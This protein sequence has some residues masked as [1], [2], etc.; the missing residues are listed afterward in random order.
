M[1]QIKSENIK[2]Y[3][4][5]SDL[6]SMSENLIKDFERFNAKK[7]KKSNLDFRETEWEYSIQ[8]GGIL[9][10]LFDS[11]FDHLDK[12][13]RNIVGDWKSENKASYNPNWAKGKTFENVCR[14]WIDN[15]DWTLKSN[16]TTKSHAIG[17]KTIAE[18]I[19]RIKT[20]HNNV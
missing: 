15:F 8:A 7:K 11:Y 4:L 9:W 18:Y 20:L 1:T 5:S 10:I 6:I 13:L 16:G 3:D 14:K 2:L 17:M 19:N 12:K